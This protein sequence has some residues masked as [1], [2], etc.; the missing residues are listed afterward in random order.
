MR[1]AGEEWD[2]WAVVSVLFPSK[3]S[4]YPLEKQCGLV[5]KVE[6]MDCHKQCIRET[7][8]I[9][10]KRF[11]EQYRWQPP[12]LCDPGTHLPDRSLSHPKS[13]QGL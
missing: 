10:G 9:L 1:R 4:W 13:C 12:E 11:K 6:C 3:L 5:Y 2:L 8:R 7:E